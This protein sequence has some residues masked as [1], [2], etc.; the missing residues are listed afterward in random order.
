MTDQPAGAATFE[1]LLTSGQLPP[2]LP[3]LLQTLYDG[4]DPDTAA[5]WSRRVGDCLEQAP[6]EVVHDWQARTV[7]P[8]MREACDPEPADAEPAEPES[9]KREPAEPATAEPAD[10]DLREMH[11]RAAAGKPFDEAQWRAALEPV[12]RTLYRRAYGY[13]EAYVTARASASAYARANDFSESGAVE[14]ADSYAK[15]STDSNQKSYAQSNAVANAAVLAAAYAS[16]DARAYAEAYPFALVH[17]CAH[18][19]AN[20]P[21]QPNQPSPA[22]EGDAESDGDRSTEPAGLRQAAYTRMADGLADSLAGV[23]R[24]GR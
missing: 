22:G 2:W 21:N 24:G 1:R 8:L 3:Q 13:A 10:S 15:L 14:F 20:R 17:A 18:A 12:L 11:A 4:Q 23:N 16:G 7:V 9:T 19:Y 6:F 5:R